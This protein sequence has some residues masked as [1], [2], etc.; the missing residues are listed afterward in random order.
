MKMGTLQ[1]NTQ[2]KHLSEDRKGAAV[3]HNLLGLEKG[4]KYHIEGKIII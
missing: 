3:C 1:R 2:E 4:I